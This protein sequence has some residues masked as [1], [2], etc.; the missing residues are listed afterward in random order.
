LIL[1]EKQIHS[2]WDGIYVKSTSYHW[3]SKESTSYSRPTKK[4]FLW[5][6]IEIFWWDFMGFI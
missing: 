6:F 3:L 1:K 4:T 5:L 2:K